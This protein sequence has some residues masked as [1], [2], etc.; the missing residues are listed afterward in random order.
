MSAASC[1]RGFSACILAPALCCLVSMLVACRGGEPPAA[2]SIRAATFPDTVKLMWPAQ[3][4]VDS[5]RA[6]LTGDRTLTRWVAGDATMAV[7]TSE[8]GVEEGASY[9]AAVYAVNRAGETPSAESPSLTANGFPWDE[10]YYT[11]LHATGQGLQTFYS[12]SH[13][14]LEQFANVPYAELACKNCHEPSLTG[15]CAS[16][17]DTPDPG[18]GAQV[19]DGV[20]EGQACAGCHGRQASEAAAG[21]SDVHRDAGMSCM[22]CH[23]LEDVMGDGH[24]YSSLLEDGAIHVECQNCHTSVAGNRY[25]DWHTSAVDCSTCHMQGMITCYNCHYQSAL[26]EG[27]SQLLKQV[28]N[29]IFL[30]NRDGKVHPANMHSLIYE[31]N[32]LLIIAPGYGHTIARNAVAGCDDCHASAHILDLDDDSVLVAAGFDGAGD[33]NTAEGLIPVPFNYETA[34]VFDFLVYDADSETW[35][36]LARGQD[37]TQFMFAEPLSDE[38]LRQLKQP[39]AELVGGS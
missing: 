29:W 28:T 33:V 3:A 32:K 34:L 22:D 23:T 11:S 25:H 14:G 35:S 39:T 15:G 31:G 18:P 1:L 37:A 36:L 7:F 13:N 12:A 6:E 8:D 20:A 24:S 27:A 2:F 26:P 16:C 19:D 9:V 17:H 30:V 4:N 5:F 10:W 21:L 38:Q